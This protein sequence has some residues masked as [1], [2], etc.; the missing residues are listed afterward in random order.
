MNKKQF[1]TF[2]KISISLLLL[3]FVYTKIDLSQII[4]L[5]KKS[6]PFIIALGILFFVFSQLI[7]SLRL[8]YIFHQNNF[9][10]D[11]LS[12]LKLY[13]VGMFYNFFI[14]GG[15]GGDAYKVF[16]LNKQF[17]WNVKDVT[18]SIFYDRLIGLLAIICLLLFVG[19]YIFSP[20]IVMLL[21]GLTLSIIFFFITKLILNRFFK[22]IDSIYTKSFIYSLIIQLLQ[23]AS[24]ICIIIAFNL[25]V[26]N[27]LNYCFTFLVSS[28]SSV[29]SFAGF[30]AREY[31]FL[32]ASTFLSVK[33]TISAS[34]GLSFNIITAIISL[35][36]LLFLNT[37]LKL[38]G[39]QT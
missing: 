13:F 2:A 26:V 5:F 18:K 14:P 6:N 33:Q 37:K 19:V 23:I 21:V 28:I 22:S 8:N 11:H 7:S 31:V 32:K 1:K 15:I 29:I 9:H 24:I 30:G 20:R 3:Y 27:Y 10:I 12:N 16:V 38:V 25:D 17:S 39:N 4:D 34:I 36:G 35:I